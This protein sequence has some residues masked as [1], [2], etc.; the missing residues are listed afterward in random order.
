M[1]YVIDGTGGLPQPYAPGQWIKDYDTVMKSGH[2][3]R[4]ATM[5][6]GEYFRGPSLDGVETFFIAEKVYRLIRRSR[7]TGRYPLFLAGHSR[8]GAATIRVAQLLKKDSISVDALFLFDAVDKTLS[9]VNVRLIPRNV[10]V[11]YHARRER[12]LATYYSDGIH[13]STKEV[14]QTEKQF[15]KNSEQCLA[16]LEKLKMYIEIDSAMK[17]RMRTG[18]YGG[19]SIDFENCG[20]GHES[21][22]NIG[23]ASSVYIERYF[24]GSHG[25]I[26]GSFIGGADGKWHDKANPRLW[27]SERDMNYFERLINNDR[28]AALSVWR[29]M[30]GNFDYSKLGLH[31]EIRTSSIN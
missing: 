23:E 29:W 15:G 27:A 3:R 8:G 28:A 21:A 26:G 1:L 9:S 4:M 31:D 20:V 10:K 17:L 6:R 16:A 24:L 22:C 12:S 11:V 2:C 13:W 14:H 19:A 5:F 7:L 18:N 25:A 30:E